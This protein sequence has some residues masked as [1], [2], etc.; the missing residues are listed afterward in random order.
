MVKN[1]HEIS[2]SQTLAMDI[3]CAKEKDISV[4]ITNQEIPESPILI[5][6]ESDINPEPDDKGLIVPDNTPWMKGELQIKLQEAFE[7]EV[8]EEEVSEEVAAFKD[9]N[10]KFCDY[11]L[12][13]E[14]D[15]ITGCCSS[16]LNWHVF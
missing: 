11:D 6:R 8:S 9:F 14:T 12:T 10:D 16:S 7:E 15:A 1:A 3:P 13:G 4:R 5:T 2:T